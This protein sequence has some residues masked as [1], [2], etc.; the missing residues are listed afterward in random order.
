MLLFQLPDDISE[1]GHHVDA[2]FW[3]TYW[4]TLAIF[5]LVMGILI[6][7]LIAHRAR[8]GRKAVHTHGDQT[9]HMI[10]TAAVAFG[11]FVG[12]DYQCEQ[13]S[14]RAMDALDAAYPKGDDAVRI[15]VRAEQ[16]AW[17]FRYP[18]ADGQFGTRDDL[19]DPSLHF[20]VGKPVLVQLRS[21]DVIHSFFLPQFRVKQDVVPELTTSIWF[22][23]VKPGKYEVACAE[24]CG[25]GHTR[26]R[27]Q[28]V[29]ESQAEYDAFLA[30]LA[31]EDAEYGEDDAQNWGWPWI[32]S[33]PSTTR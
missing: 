29:A 33:S 4:L 32:R 16:F 6:W 18:G 24:L 1:W 10:L 19:V 11:V 2:A 22:K 14:A 15:E 20:P 25:N 30:T 26:M 7:S 31:S 17:S 23:A 5:I 12:L 28:Y 21:K 13:A 3:L 27:A 8:P 9:V